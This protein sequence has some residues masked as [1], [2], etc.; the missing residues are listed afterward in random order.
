MSFCGF[1]REKLK[2]FSYSG[3]GQT[4][5]EKGLDKLNRRLTVRKSFIN[6]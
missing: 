5:E 4:R 1:I 2:L 6:S 3:Q